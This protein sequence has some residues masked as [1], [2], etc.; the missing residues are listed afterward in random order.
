MAIKL[1]LNFNISFFKL[2]RSLD[3]IDRSYQC[4]SM[5]LIIDMYYQSLKLI[6]VVTRLKDKKII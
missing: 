2:V 1:Y 5:S 3:G 6:P 4:E